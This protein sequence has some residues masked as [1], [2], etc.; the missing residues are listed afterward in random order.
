MSGKVDHGLAMLPAFLEEDPGYNAPRILE[1]NGVVMTMGGGGG[2]GQVV[3]KTVIDLG[4]RKA[5][6]LGLGITGVTNM[7]PFLMPG[8]QSREIALRG[9]VGVVL[10]NTPARVSPYGG[11]DPIL[12]TNPIGIS[13]P[14][15]GSPVTLDMAT[16]A[17]AGMKVALAKER[18]EEIPMGV[19]TNKDGHFT[20][21]PRDMFALLSFG[22]HRGSGLSVML[23]LLC[24]L[25]GGGE[26]DF[27]IIDHR[28]RGYLVMIIN[29]AFF[30][31][32]L[33][34]N[35]KAST[36]ISRIKAS[37]KAGGFEEILV[38]GERAEREYQK[39]LERGEIE[40]DGWIIEK[41]E[42]TLEECGCSALY[43]GKKALAKIK[44]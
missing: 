15:A 6:K 17:F 38:P 2:P 32:V 21:N 37:R 26:M 7:R 40:V 13:I 42:K 22:G 16:S 10:N 11:I 12:G 23:G 30:G 25:L 36:F 3:M 8:Y 14:T 29:P 41:I 33:T 35:K 39:A 31:D 24:C 9:M 28:N 5:K 19:A 44:K 20:Q 43:K 34:M 18:N 27:K 1:N 4:I